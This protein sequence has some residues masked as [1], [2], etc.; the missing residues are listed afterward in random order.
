MIQRI[1]D[2]VDKKGCWCLIRVSYHYNGVPKHYYELRKANRH[3]GGDDVIRFG[4]KN[5][6]T[7]K[8]MLSAFRDEDIPFSHINV[9]GSEKVVVSGEGMP[10]VEDWC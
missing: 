5:L 7:L 10:K 2:I 6:L 1:Y 8:R 3:T 4:G 9:I